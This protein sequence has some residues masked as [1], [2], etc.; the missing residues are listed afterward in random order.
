MEERDEGGEE[1]HEGDK[2]GEPEDRA[3]QRRHHLA[4]PEK[5]VAAAQEGDRCE[6]EADGLDCAHGAID[7]DAS[8]TPE[9][10]EEVLDG[11]MPL[12]RG[13]ERKGRGDRYSARDADEI[14]RAGN[15]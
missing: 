2:P 10:V 12:D 7:D 5:A 3:L 8:A 15:R 9:P 14:V 1:A 11:D 4:A 6:E 13:R